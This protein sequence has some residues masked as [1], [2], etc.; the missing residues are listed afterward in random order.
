MKNLLFLLAIALLS[1]ACNN[2][3]KEPDSTQGTTILIDIEEF[4]EH[5]EDYMGKEVTVTGLV[6]HVCKH[7]GQ[8]LFITGSD[9]DETLRIDVGE[10]IPEF[11]IEIE[12]SE[13]EFTG[14]VYLMSE[15]FATQAEAED[16]EHHNEDECEAEE[17]A[18]GTKE[19][20]FYLIA[21]NF[22]TR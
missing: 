15:E 22:R 17:S 8:K 16:K 9:G 7:G 19:K 2:E 12:G 4:Y 10:E 5:P 20:N 13:A 18:Q 14:I 21:Q 6:T 1:G 3:S 11:D